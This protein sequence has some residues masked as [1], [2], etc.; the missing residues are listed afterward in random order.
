M[1]RTERLSKVT[2]RRTVLSEIT[3]A[4]E[5]GDA[6]SI[7]GPP[8]SGK[9][10][11]LRILATLTQPT[12]GRAEIAGIDV[13]T[14][15]FEARKRVFLSGDVGLGCH[16]MKVLEYLR[17][18]AATRALDRRGSAADVAPL[19]ARVGLDAARNVATLSESEQRLVAMAASMASRAEVL[20][21]NEPFAGLDMPAIEC[22]TALM[23]EARARGAAIV[24]S[25]GVD[26]PPSPIWNR[27]IHLETV[28]A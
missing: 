26:A 17:L 22:C 19:I 6:V 28:G 2:G 27:Q 8:G 12:S 24:A 16:D 5:K 14:R 21:F 25:V 20:L 7:A 10:T 1:I 18:I 23:S 4:V 11:L 9:S 13:T 15:P 3:F